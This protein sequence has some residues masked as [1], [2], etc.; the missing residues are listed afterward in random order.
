[1]RDRLAIDLYPGDGNFGIRRVVEAGE[2]WALFALKLSQGNEYSNDAWGS[3]MYPLARE[4][5][6]DRYGRTGFRVPYHYLDCGIDGLT[7]AEYFLKHLHAAGDVGYG[8]PFV[9]LDVERSGQRRQ[10]SRQQ[11]VDCAASFV[12]HVHAMLGLRVV[13]YG[14]EYLRGNGIHLSSFGCEYAWVAAYTAHLPATHYTLLGID[15]AHLLAWQY[16]GL[17]GDGREVALLE[18]YPHTSPAGLC[19]LSAITLAGGGDAAIS[20]LASWCVRPA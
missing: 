15:L 4:A 12:M 17:E 3:R 9:M 20:E 19:D 6:G 10:I 2:D 18:G 7:Q 11:I 8:D 1:M 13:V 16:G 5:F 14:G